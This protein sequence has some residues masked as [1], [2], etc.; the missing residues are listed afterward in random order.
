MQLGV[1]LDAGLIAFA[2]FRLVHRC[3]WGWGRRKGGC[4]LGRFHG[5]G[6]LQDD[7]FRNENSGRWQAFGALLAQQYVDG[8]ADSAQLQRTQVGNVDFDH[9]KVLLLKKKVTRESGAG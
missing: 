5:F 7:L 9:V 8:G 4:D 2:V 6:F 1:P 3:G